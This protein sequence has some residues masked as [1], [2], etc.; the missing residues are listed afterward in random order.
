[1]CLSYLKNSE[2]LVTLY[3]ELHKAQWELTE[4]FCSIGLSSMLV[5]LVPK[6][7]NA[8]LTELLYTGTYKGIVRSKWCTIS[9]S[10]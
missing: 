3:S 4:D 2:A 9:G 7:G 6:S 10:F 5:E 8:S 1:M